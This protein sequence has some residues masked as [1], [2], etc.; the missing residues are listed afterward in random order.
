MK[1]LTHEELLKYGL[2]KGDDD[3]VYLFDMDAFGKLMNSDSAEACFIR[4]AF[5]TID[6]DPSCLNVI[7][8]SPLLYQTLF[9][10]SLEINDTMSYLSSALLGKRPKLDVVLKK[11][12]DMNERIN[13]VQQVV[14][15]GAEQV[16]NKLEAADKKPGNDS[17][18]PS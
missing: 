2:C 8:S 6:V 15:Q 14:L 7:T 13:M 10:L 12:G 5:F 1:A 4:K 3:S 16:A 11:L 18:K 9:Y 17:S